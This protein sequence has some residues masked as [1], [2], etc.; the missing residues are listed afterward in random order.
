MVMV[1]LLLTTTISCADAL[2]IIH[3]LTKVTGLTP[4]Q[5]T[6]IIQEVRK[7]IPFCPVTIKKDDK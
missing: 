1:T 5:K 3:R 4:I 2:S 7:T 6:E